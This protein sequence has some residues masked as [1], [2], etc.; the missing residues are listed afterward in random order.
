MRRKCPLHRSVAVDVARSAPSM[1]GCKGTSAHN[2]A[3]IKF[4]TLD[5]VRNDTASCWFMSEARD[6]R[7][8]SRNGYDFVVETCAMGEDRRIHDG[9]LLVF[10]RGKRSNGSECWLD[11]DGMPRNR[12]DDLEWR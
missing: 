6:V 3:A 5:G 12:E 7:K 1:L 2:A 11:F 4:C 10:T 8:W 9:S